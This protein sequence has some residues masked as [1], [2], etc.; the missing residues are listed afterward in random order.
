MERLSDTTVGVMTSMPSNGQG[1]DSSYWETCTTTGTLSVSGEW[2]SQK[3]DAATFGS[4]VVLYGPAH[5]TVCELE[6]YP[7]VESGRKLF[8]YNLLVSIICQF[9]N[10]Y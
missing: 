10:V 4:V 3:C 9:I 7:F 8:S 6:V 2:I 1:L 5:L